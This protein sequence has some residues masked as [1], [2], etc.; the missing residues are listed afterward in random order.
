M[1]KAKFIPH[2]EAVSNEKFKIVNL[3]IVNWL[4]HAK[5]KVFCKAMKYSL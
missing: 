2:I 1:S 5:K 4:C 3:L